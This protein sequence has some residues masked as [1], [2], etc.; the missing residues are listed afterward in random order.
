M[1]ARTVGGVFASWGSLGHVTF[2]EPGALLGF[3]GPRVVLALMGKALPPASRW[4]RTCMR[5][6]IDGVVDPADSLTGTSDQCDLPVRTRRQ[7][8]RSSWLDRFWSHRVSLHP[9]IGLR[10][11]TIASPG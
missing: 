6:R 10:C 1:I 3:T 7:R 5:A 11:P 9:T 4:S 8:V 2:A